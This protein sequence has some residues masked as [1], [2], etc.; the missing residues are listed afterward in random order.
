MLL[1]L[2]LMQLECARVLHESLLVPVLMYGSE[3]M[4]RKKERSRIR[5]VRMDNLRD[6]LS[7]KRMDKVPNARIRELC[8][9]PK[10]VDERISEGVL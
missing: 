1:G 10:G 8:G 6:I 7:I 2:W 3:T 4:I 9:V 5:T